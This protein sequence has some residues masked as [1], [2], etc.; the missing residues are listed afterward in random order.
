M[1]SS[2]RFRAK[3]FSVSGSYYADYPIVMNGFR[4]IINGGLGDLTIKIPLRFEEAYQKGA[5]QIM[6][7]VEIYTDNYLLYSGFIAGIIPRISNDTNE[8]SLI[9]RGHAARFSFLPL[10]NGTTVRLYT[11]SSTGLKTSASAS[12][13][14]LDLIMKAII[15]YYNAEAVFPIINYTS[16]SVINNGTVLADDFNDNNIDRTKWATISSLA[17]RNETNGQLLI[18]AIGGTAGLNVSGYITKDGSV[19]SLIGGSF[20]IEVPQ[21]TNTATNALT[22]INMTHDANNFIGFQQRGGTLYAFKVISGVTTYANTASY[23]STNHRWWR[24]RE[25]GGTTYWDTS[26]DGSSWTNFT[27]AA[28]PIT[29]TRIAYKFFAGTIASET[30]PGAAIF[31][32]VSIT[33]TVP[34]WTYTLQTKSIQYALDKVMENAPTNWYW[35]VGADNVFYFQPRSITP[36]VILNYKTQI[37][38]FEDPQMIDGMVNRSYFAYNGSPAASAKL[39]SDTT[40]S[41]SYGDWWSWKTDGRYTD[42]TQVDNV[43]QAII[44]AKKNPVRRTVIEVPDSNYDKT[45]GYDIELFE[46]GQ[47]I[48]ITNL[49]DATSAVLPSLFTIVAVDYT[50]HKARLELETYVDDIAR[51]IAKKE[52]QDDADNLDDA[53]ATYS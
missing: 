32:N 24:I 3:I 41:G 52:M 17:A 28:N 16:A 6:F 7:R 21:V 10:K 2:K 35:R 4:K 34:T 25:S 46:P 33:A 23:N 13:S 36:D 18:T 37:N 19:Y 1:T 38:Y 50:P 8:V 22:Q 47:T 39:T 30:S 42:D 43:S 31:D 14:S 27:S 44:D 9:C 15:D 11:D 5:L 53:P 48:R 29:L 26:A 45:T 49:P 20:T 12:A 51:E 40:S